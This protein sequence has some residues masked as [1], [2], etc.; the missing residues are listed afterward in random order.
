[1]QLSCLDGRRWCWIAWDDV[2]DLLAVRGS[3]G[4][5][6]KGVLDGLWSLTLNPKRGS[7]GLWY[8]AVSGCFMVGFGLQGVRLK[9]TECLG[10]QLVLALGY[11]LNALI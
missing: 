3:D 1:M 5:S 10:R 8:L 7:L 9:V 2:A 4:F 11:M 6:V